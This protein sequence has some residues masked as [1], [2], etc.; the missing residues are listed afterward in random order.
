MPLTLTPVVPV[1]LTLTPATPIAL[2]LTASPTIALTLTPVGTV[3]E[4]PLGD[5]RRA[6]GDFEDIKTQYDTFGDLKADS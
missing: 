2:T 5:K 6:N 4:F 1:S 3:S